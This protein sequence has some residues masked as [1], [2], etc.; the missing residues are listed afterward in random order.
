MRA[1][2]LTRRGEGPCVSELSAVVAGADPVDVFDA[3]NDKTIKVLPEDLLEHFKVRQRRSVAP[4]ASTSRPHSRLHV[5]C[6]KT[7][8]T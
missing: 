6:S 2:D 7:R 4:A 3:E 5:R 8:C 1:G